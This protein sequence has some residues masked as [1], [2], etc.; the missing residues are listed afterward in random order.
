MLGEFTIIFSLSDQ[1]DYAMVYTSN[2]TG[3]QPFLGA[4][5]SAQSGVGSSVVCSLCLFNMEFR[6]C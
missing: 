2:D 4:G 5:M 1:E 3:Q 6:G